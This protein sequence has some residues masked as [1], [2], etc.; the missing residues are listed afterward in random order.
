[1]LRAQRKLYWE[2][3]KALAP[4]VRACKLPLRLL[5]LA[6]G[7]DVV[8]TEELIDKKL[9]E[10]ERIQHGDGPNGLVEYVWKK[11]RS[12]VMS[13]C[14]LERERVVLQI[15]SASPDLVVRA[16]Q[17]YERDIAGV[18]I[19]MGCPKH[20]SISGGMGAA[21]LRNPETAED[22][23]RA[24]RRTLDPNVTVTCKIRLLEDDAKTVELVRRL[25]AAGAQAI[26]VHMRETHHRPREPAIWDRLRAVVDAVQVPV[27]ANGDVYTAKDI[28]TLRG[29]HGAKSIMIARGALGNPSVFRPEG[30]LPIFDVMR[31]YTRVAR[32]VGQGD[33]STIWMLNQ[34]IRYDT[35]LPRKP[36]D[37]VCTAIKGPKP[38]LNVIADAMGLE[39]SKL[40]PIKD[41]ITW[42][43]LGL[44]PPAALSA[45]SVSATLLEGTDGPP[46]K[47][48]KLGDNSGESAQTT[49]NQST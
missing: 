46:A 12:T 20:F 22:M 2:G 24:L 1:M 49:H 42:E 45:S 17:L 15:G 26:G 34:M 6:Y 30:P 19:N 7:A 9:V 47:R 16:A 31:D 25:E 38:D 43:K 44:K 35:T 21:L 3:G 28:D 8:Y 41:D 29:D 32:L 18:D 40:L 5:C 39:S 36:K 48:V 27:L 33:R 23:L 14:A 11:D 37:A 4:M 13:T 10:T